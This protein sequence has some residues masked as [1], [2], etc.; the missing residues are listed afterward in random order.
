MRP[1]FVTK[2]LF[3][4][5]LAGAAALAEAP[6]ATLP[7]T[8]DV[9]ARAIAP[10]ELLRVVVSGAQIDSLEGRFLG[11]PFFLQPEP[12]GEGQLRWSGWTMIGLL[13]EPGL[14]EI[15]VHGRAPDGREVLEHAP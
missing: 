6:S 7:L 2:L 14:A 13:E 8:I 10:G 11:E 15:E 4:A 3:P 5:V 1:R 9:H 12:A